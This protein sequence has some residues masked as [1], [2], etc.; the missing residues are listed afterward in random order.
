MSGETFELTL[1]QFRSVVQYEEGHFGDVKST[2]IEPSKMS[3]SISAFANADGGELWIGID[4]DLSRKKRSWRGF[5]RIEDANAHIQIIT[6]IVPFGTEHS[7]NFLTYTGAIGYVLH[8]E[9]GKSHNIVKATDHYPYIRKSAQNIKVAGELLRQLERNKGITSVETDTVAADPSIITNS[10]TTIRFILNVVPSAEPEEWLR[11]QQVIVEDK[12]TVAGVVLFC[13]EPQTY[14]P[15]RSGI[16]IYRYTSTSGEGTRETLHGDPI[17]IEGNAYDMINAAVAKTQEI[18]SGIHKLGEQGFEIV[19]YPTVTLHEIITNAVLHRDYSMADDIH[20]RIFDNR[21]EIESPGLL[22]AHITEKNILKERFARN[23]VIV[24]L[25]NKFP[26][27]PNKDVGEGLNTA[28]S[29]MKTMRLREPEIKQGEHSV[30]VYIRHTRLSSPEEAVI[31]YLNAHPQITNTIGREL[32]GIR[33]ENTMKNVFTRL[34]TRN[35]IEHVPGTQGRNSAWRRKV[36]P[37]PV[38]EP[39]SAPEPEPLGKTIQGE[40]WPQKSEGVPK[41]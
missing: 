6:Q 40:F 16:K 2:A 31:E 7:F 9:I 32:T 37:A 3:Q 39:M 27:P 17:S 26:N 19:S 36:V 15:K 20:V 14:L 41:A 28:F 29:A 38:P 34:R 18:I 4:E 13:D 23:G 12:P 22:P 10:A 21:V 8:I 11:K 5:A 35:L 25:I 24:R 33:S 30:V 1:E